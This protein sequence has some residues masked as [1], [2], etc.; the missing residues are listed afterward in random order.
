[1]IAYIFPGQGSQSPGMGKDLYDSFSE[2]RE[3]Y[4][5]A[6]KITGKD[7]AAISFEGSAEVLSQTENTQPCLFLHSSALL[8]SL[9]SWAR[10]QGCAGHSLGEYSALYAAKVLSFED[11]LNA[12]V[13]RGELMSRAEAGGMLV[14]LGAKSEVVEHIVEELAGRGPITVANYN[15]PGQL[16][17]SGKESLIEE[18]EKLFDAEKSARRVIRLPVSGAFHSPLMEEASAEMAGILNELE[19]EPPKVDFFA[20]ASGCREKSPDRIREL[21]I[22]QITHPVLWIQQVESMKEQ[23]FTEFV[24]VGVGKVLRGLIRRIDR[25]LETGGISS[26]EDVDNL[27]QPGK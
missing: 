18:A 17:V 21:L 15:A 7:F 9:G 23:G 4:E 24:E 26:A 14:P 11:A 10:F 5:R 27:T 16:V 20:N 8:H 25:N 19:F 22:D 12:V 6:R 3:I 13:R 1:M 2:A